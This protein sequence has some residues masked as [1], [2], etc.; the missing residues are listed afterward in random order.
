MSFISRYINAQ[1]GKAG[2]DANQW[3]GGKA[4]WS[5]S[6]I[7]CVWKCN[8]YTKGLYF[9]YW[10]NQS[11]AR[12]ESFHRLPI[13]WSQVSH[14]KR[15][16]RTTFTTTILLQGIVNQIGFKNA[17]IALCLKRVFW[18][19]FIGLSNPFRYH[20]RPFW[21]LLFIFKGANWDH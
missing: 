13:V 6:R 21:G 16:P 3:L 10:E 8:L 12:Q 11:L 14:E 20:L 2:G 4:S 15:G 1:K 19:Y 18:G 5:N 9:H 7:V 17:V